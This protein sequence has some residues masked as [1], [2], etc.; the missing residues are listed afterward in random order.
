MNDR[1]YIHFL[2]KVEQQEYTIRVYEECFDEIMLWFRK[3]RKY[4]NKFPVTKKPKIP[5]YD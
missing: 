5:K 1:D 2:Q 3:N 4:I